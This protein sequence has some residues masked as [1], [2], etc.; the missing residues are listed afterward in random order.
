[1]ILAWSLMHWMDVR[2]FFPQNSNG[3]R[4]GGVAGDDQGL[5]ASCHQLFCH[6][7]GKFSNFL[8]SFFSIGGIGG[9]TE[10]SK[11]SWIFLILSIEN[12]QKNGKLTLM[13]L[14]FNLSCSIIL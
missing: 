12:V 9:I 10:I 14:H 13:I 6:G 2:V 8:R 4:G 7:E 5:T 11:K 3:G 1:M